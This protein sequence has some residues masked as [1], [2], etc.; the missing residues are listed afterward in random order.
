M[1]NATQKGIIVDDD[2]K[3]ITLR[4][5]DNDETVDVK[6]VFPETFTRIGQEVEIEYNYL[7]REDSGGTETEGEEKNETGDDQ[8][9]K[10]PS[11][12][13]L[14]VQT[15]PAGSTTPASGEGTA[16]PPPPPPD[17]P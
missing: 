4:I 6:I 9:G 7:V 1:S 5:T 12:S 17:K 11:P 3:S 10:S 8:T 15:P 13:E 16:T 14:P 2:A